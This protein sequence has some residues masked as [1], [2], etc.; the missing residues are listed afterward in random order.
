MH[1]DLMTEVGRVKLRRD[2]TIGLNEQIM[3]EV[4]NRVGREVYGFSINL[5]K[6]GQIILWP[7]NRAEF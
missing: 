4:N 7:L 5:L 6:D 2:N 3:N 1:M